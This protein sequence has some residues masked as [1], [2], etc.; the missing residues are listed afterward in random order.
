MST[1]VNELVKTLNSLARDA[2][3]AARRLRGLAEEIQV[4]Q[5]VRQATV[6]AEILSNL[7]GNLPLDKLIRLPYEAEE[8]K[9]LEAGAKR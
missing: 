1:Q 6:A 2:E 9:R 8:L 5:D 7:I 3:G 4:S